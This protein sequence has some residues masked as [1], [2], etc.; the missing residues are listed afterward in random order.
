MR[1]L[2]G[3]AVFALGLLGG[4]VIAVAL[5]QIGEWL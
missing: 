4:A 3:I 5:I 1:V 2:G